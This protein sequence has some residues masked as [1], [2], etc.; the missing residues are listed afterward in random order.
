M[1]DVWNAYKNPGKPP[2]QSALAYIPKVVTE[3]TQAGTAVTHRDDPRDWAPL[4]W[5]NPAD[6]TNY[7]RTTQAVPNSG[8][9]QYGQQVSV[10]L[11][12]GTTWTLAGTTVEFY[13][14]EPQYRC[15]PRASFLLGSVTHRTKPVRQVSMAVVFPSLTPWGRRRSRA[16]HVRCC[17]RIKAATGRA[18]HPSWHSSG[19]NW[20]LERRLGPGPTVLPGLT[21]HS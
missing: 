8:P 12:W 10:P 19:L 2:L 11:P 16:P 7:M 5:Y 21:S 9:A 4:F 17:T 1:N 6:Q 18:G 15:F 20:V 14:V 3:I 13:W